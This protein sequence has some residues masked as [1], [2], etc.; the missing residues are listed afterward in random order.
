MVRADIG[1]CISEFMGPGH[2]SEDPAY[3]CLRRVWDTLRY[4]S[5]NW[6]RHLCRAAPPKNEID[7]LFCALKDFLCDKLLFW[8]E[9]MNLIGGKYECSSLLKDAET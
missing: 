9:T 6:A 8:I 3:D 4:V 5:S 2:T 1:R 7:D